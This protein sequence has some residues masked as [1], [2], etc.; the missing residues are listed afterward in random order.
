MHGLSDTAGL[1]EAGRSPS[2]L[3]ATAAGVLHI[4]LMGAFA[5]T[6]TVLTFPYA[7]SSAENALRVIRVWA[8]FSLTTLRIVC[9]VTYRVEGAENIPAGPAVVAANHQS[10][11]ETVALFALLP[12]PSVVFKRDLLK[13]PFYGWWGIWSGSI[14]V[15]RAAGPQSIRLLIRET[16]DRISR[17]FQLV[18]FPEGTRVAPGVRAPLQPGVAAIYAAAN[19]PVVPA[20]HDSGLYWRHPGFNRRPGA[21]TLR[22]L[23]PIAPG[24][25]RKAFESRLETA[26]LSA[27]RDL[28]P[29]PMRGA[30]V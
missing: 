26:M 15:D 4:G 22:F 24:L 6:L 8:R 25:D 19:V 7:L 1:A 30:P 12:R 13:V 5:I 9:G 14:P 29:E 2:R 18:I 27:R 23:P 11:W 10:M 3:G 21:I 28:A 17:D 16:R 20:V